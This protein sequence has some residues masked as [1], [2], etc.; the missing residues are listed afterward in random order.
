MLPSAHLWPEKCNRGG[1][2]RERNARRRQQRKR[3]TCSSCQQQILTRKSDATIDNIKGPSKNVSIGDCL[4]RKVE[5]HFRKTQRETLPRPLIPLEPALMS[6]TPRH[7]VRRLKTNTSIN[8]R[9]PCSTRGGW[10][11]SYDASLHVHHTLPN[12]LTTYLVPSFLIHH[13]HGL[14]EHHGPSFSSYKSKQPGSPA[15]KQGRAG[16]GGTGGGY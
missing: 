15:I 2:G 4:R 3:R 8:V 14:A 6:A 13:S 1:G 11:P 9:L 10:P 7:Q 16:W 12:N 5:D